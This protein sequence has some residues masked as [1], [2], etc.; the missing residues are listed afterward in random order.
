MLHLT[1]CIGPTRFVIDARRVSQVVARVPLR[2]LPKSEPY[3]AGLLDFRGTVLAVVDLATRLFGT[4]ALEPEHKDHY[5][6]NQT[7]KSRNSLGLIAEQVTELCQADVPMV[8]RS[9]S[10]VPEHDCL[11][12]MCELMANWSSGLMSI[13]S[14]R[15]QCASKSLT[16]FRNEP[17]GLDS[18][19]G[20]ASQ[21]IGLE[22]SGWDQ[23]CSVNPSAA[24]CAR[25]RQ[26]PCRNT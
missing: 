25:G 16:K 3:V 18:I 14:C 7:C 12:R 13:A 10:E 4:L 2:I 20:P 21:I 8:D 6:S 11:G 22:A 17:H 26:T 5:C 24:A 15:N 23:P 1:F 9:G 19:R